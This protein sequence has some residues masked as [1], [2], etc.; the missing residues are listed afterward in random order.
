MTVWLCNS[1]GFRI[2]EI[3]KVKEVLERFDEV[4]LLRYDLTT[5]VLPKD[6]HKRLKL[7]VE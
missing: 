3:T 4:I 2:R 1:G 5:E 7:E 6:F